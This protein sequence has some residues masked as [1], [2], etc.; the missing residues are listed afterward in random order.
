MPSSIHIYDNYIST[1][2]GETRMINMAIE[3]Y[4]SPAVMNKSWS[5]SL[6]CYQYYATDDEFE[7]TTMAAVLILNPSYENWFLDV[8]LKKGWGLV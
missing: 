7:N 2:T 1:S 3:N 8:T 4:K 5:V 6:N